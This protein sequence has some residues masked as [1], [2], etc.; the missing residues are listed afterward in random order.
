M[1]WKNNI[2]VK[3]TQC[4]E[5]AKK[6]VPYAEESV[7]VTF[8]NKGLYKR[9]LKDL[10]SITQIEIEKTDEDLE[11]T[12]S[13]VKV[14]LKANITQSTCSCPSKT[15]CK[16]ILMG[17]I[18]VSEYVSS[19]NLSN[20]D[21]SA[22][23]QELKEV[24][25]ATLCKQAGKRLFEEAIHLIQDG[26][27]ADL[28]EKDML[29]ATINIEN[30]TVYFPKKN[31]LQNAICKCGNKGLCK[32]KLIAILSYLNNQKELHVIDSTNSI[33]L[34]TD[35]TISL[36]Y[37]TNKFI[38]RIL[39]KG[40][41]CCGENEVESAIQYSIWME[42]HG[43]GNLAR[44]L[45]SLSSDLENMLNKNVGFSQITT[46][47]T[48]SRLYNTTR[49]ILL[50]QQNNNLLNQLIE[51]ARSH[52]YTI[53][54][55]HFTALG[56]C[57][58]Q[59]RSGYFGIT[60][61]FFYEEKQTVCTYTVSMANYYERT[62]NLANITNLLQQYRENKHWDIS[63][64]LFTLSH[65]RF[66][67]QNFK[68]NKLNH[69]SSSAQ[70]QCK[71]T[72]TVD[73]ETLRNMMKLPLFTEINIKTETYYNYFQKKQSSRLVLIPFLYIADTKF[74]E[75]EQQLYILLEQEDDYIEVMLPYGE[76][77]QNAICYLED[78]FRS[79]NNKL[80]YMICQTG[81]NGFIPIAIANSTGIDNFYFS[82]IKK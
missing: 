8:A 60:A 70:T 57:P 55:G 26:W 68:L 3:S 36:L 7:L 16:H 14:I 29:E 52:Y 67:L 2:I 49:L 31:S 33:S 35:K 17:I 38:T 82:E 28:V 73:I 51:S 48:L 11:I 44:L 62:E 56:A 77:S 59:T 66:T 76:M 41:I 20:N 80:Q 24:D 50:N 37:S 46:F 6:F 61:Y 25:I 40:L 5:L 71:L 81:Q 23:W 54:I 9:A 4:L 58:W 15:V 1:D 21:E 19:C 18:S 78:M 34:L 32:H 69:L 10:E 43:I 63:T 74:V 47:S 42:N 75:T 65:S 53:P 13:D 64:S 30:I 72:G 39:D 45:R 22:P 27:V 79:K 12:L